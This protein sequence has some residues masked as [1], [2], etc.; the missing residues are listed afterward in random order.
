MTDPQTWLLTDDEQRYAIKTWRYLRMAMVGLLAGLGAAVVY[1]R[2]WGD[3]RDGWER[4]ISAY[5]YTNAE[6]VFVGVL[7]AMG[8]C[9]ICLR[10][11]TEWEDILLNVAGMLAP[12]VA[13]VPTEYDGEPVLP[14]DVAGLQAREAAEEIIRLNV[15]N[16]ITALL[17]VGFLGLLFVAVRIT[18]DE[19]WSS[20][21][22]QLGYGAAVVLWLVFLVLRAASPET[23]VEHGH[24]SAYLMFACIVAVA[25]VNAFT[26][27][28]TPSARDD[29]RN[30]YIAIAALMSLAVPIYFL[31]PGDLDT[32]V[33]EAWALVF[34]AAFWG[35]QTRDLW[36]RGLR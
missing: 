23:L 19:R 12:V 24:N 34:F 5:Y 32:L 8:T 20:Q 21:A 3:P 36:G 2:F 9:L 31:F 13:L 22:V 10:G 4:S 27:R 33:A 11:S 14:G 35:F 29:L 26:F 6:P 1:E 28:R 30:W 18:V 16:N 7:I 25:V 17:V 15:E